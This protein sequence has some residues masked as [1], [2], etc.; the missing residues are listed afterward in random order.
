MWSTT[1]SLPVNFLSV[2][3]A[4]ANHVSGCG[5]RGGGGGGD[6]FVFV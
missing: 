1:G 3:F 4:F 5:V 2:V 6:G